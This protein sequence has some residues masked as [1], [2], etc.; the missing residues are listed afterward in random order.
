MVFQE[1]DSYAH[2][3]EKS[4]T[5]Q[6]SLSCETS[7]TSRVAPQHCPVLRM[8]KSNFSVLQAY[9]FVNIQSVRNQCSIQAERTPNSSGRSAQP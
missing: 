9:T 8:S 3:K 1:S 6:V 5:P 4:D 2:Q 7:Y